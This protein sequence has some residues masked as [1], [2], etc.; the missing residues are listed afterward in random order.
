MIVGT[1]N[2]ET[3]RLTKAFSDEK[4]ERT[5]KAETECWR[6]VKSHWRSRIKVA[7]ATNCLKLHSRV[8]MEWQTYTLHFRQLF[9]NGFRYL[10]CCGEFMIA[11]VETYDLMPGDATPAGG[12]LTLPE[13]GIRAA[14]DSVHLEV[15]HETPIDTETFLKISVGLANLA[16][17]HFGPFKIETNLFEIRMLVPMS[18]AAAAEEAMLTL[19]SFPDEPALAKKLDMTL[20]TRQWHTIFESGS[21]RLRIAVHPIAFEAVR[22]HRYNPVLGATPSQARRAKRLTA[23]AERIPA[24]APYAVF[25]DVNLT[26]KEPALSSEEKLFNMLMQKA[27]IAKAAFK[28]K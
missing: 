25:L 28:I 4:W 24:Y 22:I 26:E 16:Q 23:G 15:N 11:A 8:Q 20:K 19:G 9:S 6:G 12:N 13:K 17:K 10:D 21:Q 1:R 7:L 27:D 14:V 18:T 5:E 3:E 2:C